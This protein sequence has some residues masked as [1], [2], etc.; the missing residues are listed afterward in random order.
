MGKLFSDL[1]SAFDVI[2]HVLLRMSLGRF[3]SGEAHVMF[4][5]KQEM[6]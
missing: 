3:L 1:T 6:F 4:Y 2:S 5:P